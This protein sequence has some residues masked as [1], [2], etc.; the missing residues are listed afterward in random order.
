MKKPFSCILVTLLLAG[1]AFAQSSV[2][3]QPLLKSLILPGWGEYS[4]QS[5]SAYIFFGTELALW[6]GFGGLRYSAS[7]QNRDLIS[8]TTLHAGLNIYPDNK[9]YWA[10]LGNYSSYAD[11][12]EAMLENRTPEDIWNTDYTWEWDSE[13]AAQNYRDL[14]RKKE[15]TSLSSEFVITGFIVNRIASA[16]NIKYLQQKNMQL[17]AFA[18]PVK[19]GGYVHLGLSF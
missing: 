19:G 15:L 5:K 18:S 14:Y 12:R 11:H 16:I 6:I 9:Q 17:S 7:I 4:Y 8:Y 10:D 3:K 2:P 1:L 13:S